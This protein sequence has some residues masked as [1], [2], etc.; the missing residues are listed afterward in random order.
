M[1]GTDEKVTVVDHPLVR[2]SLTDLR[3]QSTPSH[4]FRA[5]LHRLSYFLIYEAMKS[6][7]VRDVGV[8]TPVAQPGEEVARL[9]D[10]LGEQVEP[11]MLEHHRSPAARHTATLS[12][13]WRNAGLPIS[14]GR[15]GAHR[16]GLRP[17]EYRQVEAVTR[18]MKQR[19]GYPVAPETVAV[20]TPS[21]ASP[22]PIPHSPCPIPYSL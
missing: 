8:E 21:S 4:E 20:P 1:I 11:G 14:T 10:F 7:N 9:C 3:D 19:L 5:L 13:A 12:E 22:S 2:K 15:V 16:G 18:D 6:L 17:D